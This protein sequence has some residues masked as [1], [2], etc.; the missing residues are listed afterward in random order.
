MTKS[1][2]ISEDIIMKFIETGSMRAAFDAVMGEGSY[3]R[4][5]GELYDALKKNGE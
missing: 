2:A 1:Q 5:A 4:L 3:E